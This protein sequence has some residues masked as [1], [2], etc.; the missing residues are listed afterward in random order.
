MPC[1]CFCCRRR[2]FPMTPVCNQPMLFDDRSSLG[3]SPSSPGSKNFCSHHITSL[4]LW[5]RKSAPF[6]CSVPMKVWSFK[7]KTI[8]PQGQSW[9]GYSFLQIL[10]WKFEKKML[11]IVFFVQMSRSCEVVR[12]YSFSNKW[13]DWGEF[14]LA[15]MKNLPQSLHAWRKK[16]MEP[17]LI[18]KQIKKK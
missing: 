6:A 17:N 7:K 14:T 13:R 16:S 2:V 5:A 4:A 12:Q 18:L 15:S 11:L 10:I 3:Q 8:F 1:C 9:P